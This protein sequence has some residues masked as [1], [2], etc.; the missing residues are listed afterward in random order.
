MVSCS[1]SFEQEEW[2]TSI[3]PVPTPWNSPVLPNC[4]TSA[5][6]L[7]QSW[8]CN[9]T[10]KFGGVLL[11]AVE[12]G[13][14]CIFQATNH[15]L[16]RRR[17]WGRQ[18]AFIPCKIWYRSHQ[19]HALILHIRQDLLSCAVEYRTYPC[20]PMGNYTE[21]PVDFNNKLLSRYPAHYTQ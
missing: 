9:V 15:D 10:G 14:S 18:L 21:L 17:V 6:R 13:E 20:V 3:T 12:L 7:Q 16:Q 19:S 5:L 8:K 4:S 11:E 2:M 1:K